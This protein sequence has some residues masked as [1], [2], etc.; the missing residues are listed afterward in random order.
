MF[1]IIKLLS[2]DEVALINKEIAPLT[3]D[4]GQKTAGKT[5]RRVK[6]NSQLA[7]FASTAA[8]KLILEKIKASPELKRV[9]APKRMSP[10]LLSKYEP[11]MEYGFHADNVMMDGQRVRSDLAFTIFLSAPESYKGGELEIQLGS[12]QEAENKLFKLTAGSMIVYPAH[13]IHRV[14]KL[15]DGVR[16]ATVGWIQSIFRDPEQRKIIEEISNAR[17]LLQKRHASSSEAAGLQRAANSLMRIWG[18]F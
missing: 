17:E 18:D 6:K 3:F 7:N 10:I 1:N 5:A 13:F 15:D 14:R 12:G 8:H 9:A 4:D 2:P 11:R 16:L